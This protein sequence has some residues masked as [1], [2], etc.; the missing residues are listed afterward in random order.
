MDNL[1]SIV[2]LKMNEQKLYVHSFRNNVDIIG[3][4]GNANQPKKS[5]VMEQL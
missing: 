4:E 3:K 1:G 2:F 5:E